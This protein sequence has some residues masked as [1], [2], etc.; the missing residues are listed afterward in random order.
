MGKK[1]KMK[2]Q[3]VDKKTRPEEII[4]RQNK[5]II[6]LLSRQVFGEKK[7]KE[8]VKAKKKTP[9]AYIKGYNACDGEKGLGELAKVIGVTAGTLSPILQDWE[10]KGIIYDIGG[11]GKPLYVKLMNLEK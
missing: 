9:E 2:G 7:I 8:L 3:K 6:S 5:V 10:E 1:Q 4:A 11:P